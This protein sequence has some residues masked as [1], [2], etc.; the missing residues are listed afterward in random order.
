MLD[1]DTQVVLTQWQGA[2]WLY[3]LEQALGVEAVMTL[4]ALSG[5]SAVVLSFAFERR[6]KFWSIVGFIFCD[7]PAFD[8]GTSLWGLPILSACLVCPNG[9]G[10]RKS[11]SMHS[12]HLMLVGKYLCGI[13]CSSVF[14]SVD[15]R[16][17][18]IE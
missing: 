6:I 1:V 10:N 12:L 18:H 11:C 7:L 15:D 14:D 3:N 13:L 16:F 8:L 2:W 5:M 17:P 9:I 4:R